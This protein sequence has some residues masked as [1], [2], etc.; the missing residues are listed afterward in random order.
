MVELQFRDVVA[1]QDEFGLEGEDGFLMAPVEAASFDRPS[2]VQ[3]EQE[4]ESEVS[5]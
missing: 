1:S 4:D 3:F 2:S 5:F